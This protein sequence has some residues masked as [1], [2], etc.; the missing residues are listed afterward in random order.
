M[1]SL[2]DINE[3]LFRELDRLEEA[4]GDA[5]EDEIARAKAIKDLC[6]QAIST[7]NTMLRAVE[8]QN[9][10]IGETAASVRVPKELIGS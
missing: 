6:Q 7:A 2:I 10:A 8:L 5:L 3:R 1:A 4:E 9:N